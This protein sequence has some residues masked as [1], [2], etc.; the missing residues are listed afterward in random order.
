MESTG[1]QPSSQPRLRARGAA[2]RKVSFTHA[3]D[4]EGLGLNVASA[5]RVDL[6]GG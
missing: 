6:V 2:G 1:A 5:R 3:A 4:P